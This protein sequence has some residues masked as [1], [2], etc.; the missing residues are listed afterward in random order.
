MNL[1]GTVNGTYTPSD[2]LVLT[3]DELEELA[4]EVW[5]ILEL[6]GEI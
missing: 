2:K 1:D 4:K 6:Y 3:N 5:K